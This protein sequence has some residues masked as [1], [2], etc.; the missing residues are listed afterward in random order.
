MDLTVIIATYGSSVWRDLAL[1]R[2]A[3]S[4]VTQAQ[5]IVHHDHGRS[6][7]KARNHAA[8]KATTRWL[9]FLDA[10][11]ELAPGYVDAMREARGDL[12]APAVSWIKDGRETPPRTLDDRHIEQ[13]NPC[14]I[15]TLIR[16]DLFTALG[17]FHEWQAWEDWA[18][19]LTA[20]RRGA[21]IE[22]VPAAVYRAHVRRG[23][24]NRTVSNPAELHAQILQASR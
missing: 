3:P 14:V 2:A 23:S 19:F 11:D 21:K 20:V 4:A 16:R 18:L 15:G 17:G 6:I 5:T 10:D 24:R 8:A 12:R 22:H 9:C 1:D 7:A 13:M